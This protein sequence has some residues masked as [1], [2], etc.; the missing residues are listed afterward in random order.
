MITSCRRFV[1]HHLGHFQ[2]LNSYVLG[3]KVNVSEPKTRGPILKLLQI[4]LFE[5]WIPGS[6]H[7]HFVRKLVRGSRK[8]LGL[9]SVLRTPQEVRP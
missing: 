9:S 8:F 2:F 3:A 6:A 7:P 4:P 1:S 5:R